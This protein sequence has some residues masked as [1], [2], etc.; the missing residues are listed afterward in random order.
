MSGKGWNYIIRSKESYGIK[1]TTPSTDTFDI[2]TTITL[3]RRQTKETKALIQ[4]DPERYR[5]IQPHTTFD[6][7]RSREDNRY[8]LPIRIVRIKLSDTQSETI[9]TNLPRDKFPAETIKEMYKLRWAIE[10]SFKELK[11][12]I[13]LA[14]MHS[15]KQNLIF[16]EIFAKLT[17][18]NV[19]AMITYSQKNIPNGKRINFAKTVAVC[20]RF[21]TGK[22]SEESLL[23]ILSK[24]LSPIR[25]GRT[26]PRSSSIKNPIS[27]AYR[28]S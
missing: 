18:Y 16:Q 23:K 5:W 28:I 19:I 8:D 7:I 13:G 6:Y 3:T 14:S 10:T 20:I 9:L 21:I 4:K 1:Y 15:K 22:L 26:F 2:D 12:N 25:L 24:S 11:Y 27:F 17:I